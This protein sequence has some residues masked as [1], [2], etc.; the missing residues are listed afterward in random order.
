MVMG[1]PTR[2]LIPDYLGVL[3]EWNQ[4]GMPKDDTSPMWAEIAEHLKTA[5]V[6]LMDLWG[7]EILAE[8]AQG[9]E[10]AISHL[11]DALEVSS[12]QRGLLRSQVAA[13]AGLVGLEVSEKQTTEEAPDE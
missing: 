6:T 3:R 11:Q 4:A 2:L 8:R 10:Q 1:E 5:L 13:L 7:D 12:Q 9:L